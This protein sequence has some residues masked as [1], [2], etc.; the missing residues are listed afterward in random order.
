MK[1]ETFFTEEQKKNLE[2]AIKESEKQTSGEIRVY[3]ENSCSGEILDR[4]AYLFNL[5]EMTKT[6][7][8]NGI[9]FYLSIARQKFAVLGDAGINAKVPE[10]F[11]DSVRDVMEKYFKDEDFTGG[12]IE[13]IRMT[14]E[15]LKTY[16]PWMPDDK[17]EL[18]DAISFG[19]N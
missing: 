15:K 8:R 1:A 3:V 9:L 6:K 18:S 16:F 11:W 17:N 10:N 19:D 4:A 7:E 2:Q 14:G 5:L 13:G 12:L